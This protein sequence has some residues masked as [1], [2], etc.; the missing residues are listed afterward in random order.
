M[1]VSREQTKLGMLQQETINHS[2]EEA[3]IVHLD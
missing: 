1:S 2:R 3:P